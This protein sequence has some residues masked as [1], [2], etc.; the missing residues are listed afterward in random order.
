MKKEAAG[1]AESIQDFLLWVLRITAG[2]YVLLIGGMMPF[3]YQKAKNYT[4]IGT[5]KAK[6]YMHWG[7]D[8]AKVALLAFALY[9]IFTVVYLLQKEKKSKGYIKRYFHEFAEGLSII[10]R[11]VILYMAALTISFIL[12][13]FKEF[14][15][16]GAAGW[17]MGYVPQMVFACSYL[18]I[19]R[20]FT[21]KMALC[22]IV[23]MLCSSTGVFLLGLLNRYGIN[24]LK[25]E[26]SGPGFISTIG[27]VNW[28]AGYWSVLGSLSMVLF[29][30][31]EG[32]KWWGVLLRILLALTAMI[33][34]ATGITQGSDSGILTLVVLLGV[35]GLLSVKKEKALRC[36]MLLL[37]L[38][39]G[40]TLGLHF[41]QNRFPDANHYRT[42]VYDLLVVTNYS[43]IAVGVLAVLCILLY[44]KWTGKPMQK[45]LRV[46]WYVVTLASVATIP[47]FVFLLIQ[48]TKNPGSIG[49]LSGNPLFVFDADWGSSRGATWKSGYAAFQ[50]LS[51]LHKMFGAGPDCMA[52]LIYQGKD[53]ALTEMVQ[54]FFGKSRLTN[55]HNEWLT[56]LVNTGILGL[57]SWILLMASGVLT[58]VRQNKSVITKAC[59]MALLCYTVHNIFSFQTMNNIPQMY[60]AMA[61]GAVCMQKKE[62]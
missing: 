35:L 18:L 8:L 24:P 3:Y 17:S 16:Q 34:Y 38:F 22:S 26:S 37:F 46:S 27:N 6:F 47:F 1:V 12:T 39:A 49:V 25:M 45:I 2:I 20:V 4:T 44:L 54:G 33:A 57:T 23:L 5:A 32:K 11:L 19:S 41:V 14:A 62:Q 50:S 59:G 60:I 42:E 15:L 30:F 36:F 43:L 56:I 29:V 13:P 51:P 52:A 31:Y 55:A 7:Y 58:Y 40:T 53:S 48:N 61:V 10:D 28:Y 21:K 9:L